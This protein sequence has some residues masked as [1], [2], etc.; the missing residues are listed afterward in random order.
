MSLC[1]PDPRM[2]I[3][4][5]LIASMHAFPG[6][7]PEDRTRVVVKILYE[8]IA[9]LTNGIADN[10]LWRETFQ[11]LGERHS[12]LERFDILRA[13]LTVLQDL[14]KQCHWTM[15][16]WAQAW[17]RT[18]TPA[19]IHPAS[20]VLCTVHKF[21]SLGPA[22]VPYVNIFSPQ[23]HVSLQLPPWAP[24]VQW[25]IQVKTNTGPQNVLAVGHVVAKERNGVR[26]TNLGQGWVVGGDLELRCCRD[27]QV[28]GPDMWVLQFLRLDGCYSLK[29][30]QQC[31]NVA[32]R[33][34]DVTGFRRHHK[35]GYLGIKSNTGFYIL[36]GNAKKLIRSHKD[37]ISTV[38]TRN[39]RGAVPVPHSFVQLL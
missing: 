3:L 30:S 27:L 16:A 8:A 26:L 7:D 11:L 15:L 12:G 31:V 32:F 22:L 36:H 14:D 1:S 6:G 34:E 33:I 29:S 20:L 21:Q 25:M 38:I 19:E 17:I 5:G 37:K 39:P 10:D 35:S 2:V 24:R 13:A 28:L 4:R 23:I 18:I 9:I